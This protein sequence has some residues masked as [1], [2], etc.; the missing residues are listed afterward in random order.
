VL[1][2]YGT[3]H[4]YGYPRQSSCAIAEDRTATRSLLFGYKKCSREGAH[5]Q[6]RSEERPSLIRKGACHNTSTPGPISWQNTQASATSS[7]A[8][9]REEKKQLEHIFPAL[10]CKAL[11]RATSRVTSKLP[12]LA[13]RWIDVPVCAEVMQSYASFARSGEVK[14]QHAFDDR[15][16]GK[17][18]FAAVYT[19]AMRY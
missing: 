13:H 5:A 14:I 17:A 3:Y 15:Q 4:Q 7:G 8:Q 1:P 16:T 19:N 12:P 10:P 9:G 11:I 2:T 18:G 6:N